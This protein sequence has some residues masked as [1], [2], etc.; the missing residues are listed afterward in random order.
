M[1][2][3]LEAKAGRG[4]PAVQEIERD[5][6]TIGSAADCD[7][8]VVGEGLEFSHVSPHHARIELTPQ[9]AK[10]SD[11]GSEKGTWVN[12]KSVQQ[13]MVIRQGARFTLGRLG[14]T[15]TVKALDLSVPAV[16]TQPTREA[17][18]IKGQ[19]RG[20]GKLVALA[21][22]VLLAAGGGAA[23]YFLQEETFNPG[24][25]VGGDGDH[26]ALV[27]GVGDY[28]DSQPID[29]AS[30]ADR[31]AA[32]LAAALHQ[33]GFDVTLMTQALDDPE[34]FATNIPTANNIR[35][36]L[37]KLLGENRDLDGNDVVLVAFVG[38]GVKFATKGTRA[39]TDGFYLCPAD[40][41]I[42]GLTDTDQ[43]GGEHNLLSLADFYDELAKTDKVNT[44]LL[45]L[46]VC[47]HNPDEPPL[48]ESLQVKVLPELRLPPGRVS[49]LTS[50]S[51]GEET[52][53][54]PDLDGSP[55]VH[56]LCSA[57]MGEADAGDKADQQLTLDELREY[58]TKNT[59][60]HVATY[61]AGKK[62]QP[63]LRG[64]ESRD[65]VL[66]R[67]DAKPSTNSG[68]GQSLSS[69]PDPEPQTEDTGRHAT[70]AAS[71]VAA[72]ALSVEDQLAADAYG[73]LKKYCADC[74]NSESDEHSL[75]AILTHSE[76]VA[77]ADAEEGFVVPGKP[78]ASTVWMRVCS[79]KD[80]PPD[81][82][83]IDQPTDAERE[84][85]AEWIKAG[86]RPF[87]E[88]AAPAPVVVED[89]L[90]RPAANEEEQQLADAALA[91]IE[92]Q[93]GNCHGGSNSKGSFGNIT[94]LQALLQVGTKGI[95]YVTPGNPEESRLWIVIE[96]GRM[97]KGTDAKLTPAQMAPIKDW[98]AA[99]APSWGGG[100]PAREPIS[101]TDVFR[102]IAADLRE[103]DA[104]DRPYRRYFTLDHLY[105]NAFE[106]RLNGKNISLEQ[107]RFMRAAVSKTINSLT[108]EPSITLP[109]PIGNSIVL[110]D[111]V[112]AIDLRDYGWSA[113]QWQSLLDVYPYGLQWDADR[114][115]REL[116]D[117]AD[118]VFRMAGTKLPMLRADWFVVNS[119]KPDF[120]FDLMRLPDTAAAL[121]RDIIGINSREDFLTSR[122][123]RSGF[124]QSGVSGNNR[125]LDRH[126]TTLG[127]DGWGYYYRSYDFLQNADR[128]NLEQFPL[129]PD[130]AQN[131]FSEF[132]FHEDGGE[133]IFSLPNGMQGYYLCAGDKAT[134][135]DK[136]PISVVKDETEISGT[137][138]IVCALS[139]FYCHA[140]G[141]L[142]EF[143]D[144]TLASTRLTGDAFRKAREIYV[145][146]HEMRAAADKDQQ[147]FVRSLRVCTEPFLHADGV[148]TDV[149]EI[150]EPI[151]EI[152]KRFHGN[153]SDMSLED[154]A[155]EL[156]TT[157]ELL[158]SRIT[159]AQAYRELGLGSL[160]DGGAIKRDLW[161]SK[162]SADEPSVFQRLAREI[163]GLDPVIP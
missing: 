35:H 19:Q 87:P 61:A 65:N 46:D 67:Y 150:R 57:L 110:H 162:P 127:P 112:L 146:H 136:G 157:P 121:E 82:D 158:R 16:A 101:P 155:A 34:S 3:T 96:N 114:Q 137:P 15:V 25:F 5:S 63:E 48:A 159:G 130:F 152:A 42:R 7:L 17:A 106:T 100:V 151:G 92:Q 11:L 68:A 71:T 111:T 133:M 147:L 123:M 119:T 66:C 105:N 29:D 76:L 38:Q 27:I 163:H 59:T 139:C 70:P 45:Y 53:V 153:Q 126:D 55:A 156:Y 52:F 32:K 28:P 124:R 120:Y 39:T 135:L 84:L 49:L 107:L 109:R 97:P 78:E 2:I 79:D 54:D 103:L 115:N 142:T 90:V 108:W 69:Q 144:T 30:E 99:G 24:E 21:L 31:D 83:G 93:C 113:G 117:L 143:Q 140:N 22:L 94:N 80:M 23:F 33:R 132:A 129:G 10:L 91:F 131:P 44:R 12:G 149:T 116:S 138:E 88:V 26:F 160:P 36:Q 51:V 64:R 145:P 18:S 37:Q 148:T 62:Q 43:I 118:E 9:G 161:E 56:F 85:V 128:G 125:L 20:S 4:Q 58:V 8:A 6:I 102:A 89:G 154:A 77:A 81:E 104:S 72:A 60:H 74:H 86:A 98:I 1:K 41:N 95:P 50:C 141:V 134:R 122:V 47:R 14:P 73:V 75:H 13:P 40:A